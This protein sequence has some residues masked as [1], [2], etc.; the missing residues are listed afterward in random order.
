MK[1][2]YS[3]LLIFLFLYSSSAVLAQGNKKVS[4][5]VTDTS[6]VAISDVNVKLIAGKDTLQAIT[7]AD[8]EFSFSRIKADQFLLKVTITGYVE[9]SK[10]YTFDKE[11]QLNINDIKL[12][13][14]ANMLKEVVIKTKP[15]P[16]RI[17][18]DTVE[19]N[20]AAYQVLEGDNVADLMKQF[21][22][23]EID[24]EYNVKTMGKEM[25]KLRIN[26]QDFFTSNV[27]DFIGRLP[28]GIVSKIQIID[29][30]GDEAN[31]TGIKIGEPAKMLNIVTKPGMNKG[32]FGNVG[33]NGGTNDQIGSNANMNFW[34]DSKQSSGNVNYG[35]SNNGAGKAQNAAV[36]VSHSQTIGKD[37]R[38]GGNYG[39][40]VNDAAYANEQA[41][42]T[43]NPLGTFYNNML[44]NG[45]SKSNNHSLSSNVNFNN[46]K[47]YLNGSI[48]AGYS[49]RGNVN[50]SFSNQSGTIRQDL[51]NINDTRGTAPRV[52]ANFNL[53]KVLKNKRNS[54]SANFGFS[55]SAN[56]SNQ[57]IITNTLYYNKATQVLEKDSLLNRNLQ[58]DNSNNNVNA[59]FNYSLGLKKLKDT[60]ARQSFNLSYNISVGQSE[61]NVA[62]TV[63]DNLNN[64]PSFVDSLS[65]HYLS[66]T[67]NQSA[68]LNYNFSNKKMRYNLGLN[69]RPTL[70]RNNYINLNQ[71]IDNNTF[72]YSPNLNFSRTISKGK[73]LAVNYS[74]SNINPSLYQL[75]PIRNA[76]NLQNIIVGN[77][78]LKPAFAHN[79]SSSYNYVNAKT[80]ISIQSGLS[81]NATQ[82]E[83][84]NNVI[85]IPDTLNSLKQETRFENTNGNYNMRSNYT[86]NIPIKKNKYSISYSGSFGFSNRAVFINNVK[87]FNEGINISQQLNTTVVLKKITINST[88]AY[89]FSSNSNAINQ[90][91]ISDAT[92]LGL[93]QI[94]GANFFSTHNYRADVNAALRLKSFNVSSNIN[95]NYTA[96]NGDFG[97]NNFGD[98]QNLNLLLSTRATIKKSYRIGVNASKRINKGYALQNTD[99]FIINA[100]LSKSFFKNQ[101][102]SITVNA[103]DLLNQG[104]NLSRYVSGNSIVDS[105]MNQVTRVFTFGL[106]YN[107]SKFGGKNFYVDAD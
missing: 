107:L 78:N 19:Y 86:L 36:M 51:R 46:K 28:A 84:I 38:I 96:N 62:T 45:N 39:Y 56:N 21:P 83:I 93:G 23:L 22:G 52:N 90:N 17:M 10:T 91:I 42:E 97:N 32:R 7:N 27:K 26:G 95:Y 75:Q 106:S 16:I 59:G 9:F 80:G 68:G 100:N 31:F 57:N 44:S 29:D 73:T 49:D 48:T 5:K 94:N 101:A 103:N 99:P 34:N 6:N 102:L 11:K 20:A 24:D 25:V 30:F 82:N 14:A 54:F 66:T 67:I 65:T 58:T 33:L 79:I 41:I 72:N 77:P 50:S 69:L 55:S 64:T 8:G 89:T 71:V 2:R 13:F 60:L 4:G 74:G 12:R 92:M 70:L 47:V 105:R 18:Q 76:Q 85:L 81:F 98:I 15:N 3:F 63:F 104:N 1:N 37:L 88:A 87:D 43:L 35:T 40:M 53:S 61:S